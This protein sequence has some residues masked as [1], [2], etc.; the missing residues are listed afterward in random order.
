MLR[1]RLPLLLCLLSGVA[2]AEDDVASG[3]EGGPLTITVTARRIEELQQSVPVS[4]VSVAGR[5]LQDRGVTNAQGLQAVV[6]GLF[7]SQ[8]NARL[9]S[10][11]LRGLGSSAFNEGLE[12]S[13]ALFIDGVYLGRQ[14]MSIGD[15]VDIE[16]VEVARG[17]QG[18]L[19]GKN[20]TA[21][22]ISV[23]TRK[24]LF[25][26]EAVLDIT[27]GSLETRQY[28][29]S[30]TGPLSDTWAGRLTA[31][32]SERDGLI[33]N[34][35]D[36]QRLN[37]IQRQGVRGQLL[38]VPDSRVSTRFIAEAGLVDELCCAFP[39]KGSP[40]TAIQASDAYMRYQRVSGNPAAR[41][42]D[43]DITPRSRVEQQALSA[44]TTWDISARHRLVNLAAFRHYFFQPTTDDNTSMDLVRGGNTTDH[45]QF[46]EELRLESRWKSV[47]SVTG[48]YFL[49]QDTRGREDAIL[50]RDLSDWVFGG[51]IRQRVPTADR[52]NTG[53][54][55]RALLPPETLDGMRAVTPFRQHATSLAGFS[56]LNWH[57]TDALDLSAGLR[58]TVEW[59]DTQ[60]SRTRSGGNPS[61]SPLSLTNNLAPLGALIGQDLSGLTFDQLL[62]DTL[63]GPF[64]RDLALREQAL[65]GQLGAS[66]RWTPE[67]MSYLTISRGIKGGG[68]NL[69]VTGE[70]VQPTFRPE[71]ADSLEVGLKSLLFDERL[72]LNLAAYYTR[73][74]DY[75]ALTFDESPTFL[76]NPRLNNLLNVGRVT[77]RG[78]ELDFQAALPWQLSLRGGLAYN[79]AIT[80][81]FTNA[82][83][84]TSR[85][86]T[87][88]LSGQPLANAPLW[89]GSLALR[90]E[91][92]VTEGLTAYALADSWFRSRYNATV[93]RARD[94]EI[95]AYAVVG[96]RLG[97]R[98]VRGG[99][100]L[101]LFARN[102]TDTRYVNGIVVLYGP[103]DYGY[104]IGE[105][106]VVGGTVRLQW[107]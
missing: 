82:P 26:P 39:L 32:R 85:R 16:R 58:Y 57:V 103:G 31:Y 12:S 11:T 90:K 48:L 2:G 7:S 64:R 22:T 91:W 86:N 45:T 17:P 9:T 84:E 77:L 68:V 80:N 49:N 5:E 33:E 3:K 72:L 81:D 97:L 101:S 106:R 75:Q 74:R 29:G 65:S 1:N 104:T 38:W 51:Q 78:L 19:F 102:L 94:G 79:H 42:T 88:D 47:D 21:G 52:N 95:D 53:L 40:T 54:L 89:Q 8:A 28:R 63:G 87:Q 37:D 23:F 25:T 67:V 105:P 59:K 69:G 83:D 100:D 18:T 107:R 13:V 66:R 73:I 10:F 24:P 50:G 46:S 15:L 98:E 62:D 61:A 4:V 20:T 70:R 36:G 76:A 30:I 99:W 55:L 41:M 43:T 96:A 14:G 56:H 27:G 92:S 35:F 93:E 44:E 34:R 6:P 71:V 60:V